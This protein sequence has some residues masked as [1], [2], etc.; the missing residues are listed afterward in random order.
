[1]HR[2]RR[3]LSN[4]IDF[5]TATASSRPTTTDVT[6]KGARRVNSDCGGGAGQMMMSIVSVVTAVSEI[7]GGCICSLHK[8]TN[9]SISPGSFG[10]DPNLILPL[11]GA[12][13]MGSVRMAS[14]VRIPAVSSRSLLPQF[15]LRYNLRNVDSTSRQIGWARED[16][17]RVTDRDCGSPAGEPRAG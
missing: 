12:G 1:M 15:A 4:C 7:V 10:F 17:P 6:A 9:C 14:P 3:S 16:C 13:E 2:C 8:R 11:V 5:R